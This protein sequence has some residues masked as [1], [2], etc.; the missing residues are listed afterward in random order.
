MMSCNFGF[1]T[2]LEDIKDLKRTRSHVGQKTMVSTCT[3]TRCSGHNAKGVIKDV[4]FK[5]DICPDCGHHLMKRQI[6]EKQR[7]T[8]YY[9]GSRYDKKTV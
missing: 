7:S 2:T 8:F 3:S 6:S 5:I 4:E 9:K 1:F